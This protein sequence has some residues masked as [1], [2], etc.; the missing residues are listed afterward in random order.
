MVIR[1]EAN[2]GGAASAWILFTTSERDVEQFGTLDAG[3][4]RASEDE[5]A[6]ATAVRIRR[7]A[8]LELAADSGAGR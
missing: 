1:D 3:L 2:V 4:A 8:L 7:G 6:E 5:A